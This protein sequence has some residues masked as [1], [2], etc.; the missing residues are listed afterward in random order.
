M[1]KIKYMICVCMML[2]VFQAL[3]LP[4][5]ARKTIYQSPFVSFSPDGRAWTTHAGVKNIEI[6]PFGTTVSTGLTSS[7]RELSV[8]EHYYR[9]IR[10]GEIPVGQWRVSH[11]PGKCIHCAYPP[12]GVSYHDIQ[13]GRQFCYQQYFSGWVAFCADCGEMIPLLFYMS[14]QAAESIDY[15]PGGMEYYYLCPFCSNLEQG[16]PVNH[17]CKSIS[18]NRYRVRYN[19]GMPG[20]LGCMT[21]D[22]FMYDNATMYEGE[23]IAPSTCLSLNQFSL[24]G[25]AFDSWNTRPD[26]SGQRF[27]DGQEVLNLTEENW[28]KGEHDTGV[29][30][31]YAQWKVAS[32]TLILQLEGG[33]YRGDKDQAT[34][35]G[36]YGQ[37]LFVDPTVIQAPQGCLVRFETNGGSRVDSVNG[38]QSFFEW[39]YGNPFFGLFR[40]NIYFFRAPDGH[41]DTLTAVYRRE[42]VVL[43]ATEKEGYSFGGWYFDP[44]FKRP[45]GV[46]G[47]QLTPTEDLIL[48]AQWVDLKLTAADNYEAYDGKG[49][50]DLA[51]SQEDGENKIYRLYQ[52]TTATDFRPLNQT[53]DTTP[54]DTFEKRFAF[55]AE[56]QKLQV[57]STGVYRLEAGGARGGDYEEKKGGEGGFV[58]A[59]FWLTEGETL[60]V[61]IG[62]RNGT[63]SGGLMTP[64][65]FS[66]GGGRTLIESDRQGI[67]LIAGGGGGAGAWQE[68]KPGGSD[69]GLRPDGKAEGEDGMAGGGAGACGGTA[70]EVTLHTHSGKCQFHAHEESCYDQHIHS[71]LCYADY[72]FVSGLEPVQFLPCGCATQRFY[73]YCRYCNRDWAITI[74]NSIPCEEGHYNNACRELG[75]KNCH[76]NYLTCELSEEPFLICPVTEGYH[77]GKL[78]GVDIDVSKPGFGG[79]N[80]VSASALVVRRNE[81][82]CQEEDGE[83]AI[84]SERIGYCNSFSLPGVSAPD[85]DKPDVI[86]RDEVSR[87]PGADRS[88]KI[89]WKQPKDQGT[90]YYHKAESFL[91]MVEEPLCTSNVTKNTL[92]SGIAGYLG[93]VDTQE[94]TK[95]TAENSQFLP[96]A[97]YIDPYVEGRDEQKR[98]LHVAAVDVAGNIGDSLSISL[99]YG[100]DDNTEDEEQVKWMMETE[101][102]RITEGEN[103]YPAGDNRW[104]VRADGSK[105]ILLTAGCHM[106]GNPTEHYQPN[107]LLFEDGEA[108][109]GTSQVG[110]CANNTV[111]GQ[112]PQE[113]KGAVLKRMSVGVF[114]M[115]KS[116][117]VAAARSAGNTGLKY[118]QGF[119]VPEVLS[120]VQLH[121]IPIAGAGLDEE[122]V[123][124]DRAQ[125]EQHG[126]YLVADGEGPQILGTHAL[127]ET[128]IDRLLTGGETVTLSAIDTLSGVADW[129]VTISSPDNDCQMYF[130][131]AEDGRIRL[132]EDPSQPIWGMDV[133]ITITAYDNVG[134]ETL[135]EYSS[136]CLGLD[137]SM[138]RLREPHEPVFKAGESG[139]LTIRTTGY[140][141]SVTV[142]FPSELTA[143]SSG[144]NGSYDYAGNREAVKVEEREFMIPLYAPPDGG[145]FVTVTAKKGD[146]LVTRKVFFQVTEEGGSLL[147]QLRTRLR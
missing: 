71:S 35:P 56:Q 82:G 22:L 31:L 48:Y 118:T 43:P 73:K 76:S 137:A 124:S 109:R 23:P 100:A 18:K 70:G 11:T 91:P 131:P 47:S 72:V 49:A 123:W 15:L 4:A 119:V 55:S 68:G 117:Y 146:R 6:N 52:G 24:E 145:Y 92:V 5:S 107:F 14:R 87:L 135:L 19:P 88:V 110:I 7:L 112:T 103:V 113:L 138:R 53:T 89:T 26:G 20:V 40:N 142:S 59:D 42:P 132:Q 1:R 30:T 54:F 90:T 140:A 121:I 29:V 69:A 61:T 143:L 25:Y 21:D 58:S 75:P 32:S 38:T 2:L 79:S 39:K 62:G 101:P 147:S 57:P 111:L 114:P 134:N 97:E 85:L 106:L 17:N 128:Q 66:N 77:C 130:Y 139:R 122:T 46:A 41:T 16:A 80:Y 144:L 129:K 99:Q 116:G 27:E 10:L 95:V 127:E 126:I 60:T 141:D 105:P 115:E 125:D 108:A 64:G 45:A 50:V 37:K 78:E 104:Y 36:D 28:N 44:E 86:A 96:S 74:Y 67:L 133:R 84:Y 65:G 136:N 81:A 120:G 94:Y 12:K 98:Y 3:S 63:G 33:T 9:R 13:F 51:W 83:A 34:F 93:L 102:I 8:G